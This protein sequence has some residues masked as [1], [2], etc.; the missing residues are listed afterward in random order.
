MKKT[1][2]AALIALATTVSQAQ[3]GD[4]IYVLPESNAY[5]LKL[6][7]GDLVRFYAF[8]LGGNWT[9]MEGSD[10]G[11]TI[12]VA[13]R[14]TNDFAGAEISGS[15]LGGQ[16]S[17]LYCNP[18]PD[19]TGYVCEEGP[20]NPKLLPVLKATGSLKAIYQT[21][22]GADLVIFES[23]GIGVV[24]IFEHGENTSDR[25]WIGAYTATISDDLTILNIETVVESDTS[26]GEYN[27]GFQL[28]IRDRVNPQ[29]EFVTFTCSV[30]GGDSSG[31]IETCD[32][33]EEKY[34]S[35]LIR[36]F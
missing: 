17:S 35:K 8:S 30:T 18:Y 32:T 26:D 7:Y 12:E 13:E 15:I 11:S 16:I 34:F 25:S 22:W 5:A 31:V 1:L 33:I 36:K 10:T 9:V 23:D 3:V 28:Q 6:S 21:Q 14:T 2:L 20:E 27:L 19:D 24:V 4:G 29:A